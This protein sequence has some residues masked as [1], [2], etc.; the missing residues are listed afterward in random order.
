MNANLALFRSRSN[1]GPAVSEPDFENA[2]G[3]GGRPSYEDAWGSGVE[4]ITLQSERLDSTT[5]K[6]KRKTTSLPHTVN[7]ERF[8]SVLCPDSHPFHCC[9]GKQPRRRPSPCLGMSQ[10]LRN[11]SLPPR[12]NLCV[13]SSCPATIRYPYLPSCSNPRTIS[14]SQLTLTILAV[15]HIQ[16]PTKAHGGC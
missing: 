16:V 11:E 4:S 12:E 15:N 1:P 9:P 2:G 7:L 3:Q 6:V 5:Q 13:P 10:A 14:K 8:L